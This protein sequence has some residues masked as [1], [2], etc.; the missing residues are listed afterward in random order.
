MLSDL[1]FV[2][3]DTDGVDSWPEG[4]PGYL[5]YSHLADGYRDLLTEACTAATLG[6][7]PEDDRSL[8]TDGEALRSTPPATHEE[9]P[10][11]EASSPQEG[12]GDGQAL[13]GTSARP[14][15]P[16]ASPDQ[17]VEAQVKRGRGWR[18]AAVGR[19]RKATREADAATVGTVQEASSSSGRIT[20][21]RSRAQ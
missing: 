11:L 6:W 9:P 14:E 5:A 16:S 8:N 4:L 2:D 15:V 7:A 21:A 19:A 1:Q 17:A 12:T 18:P 13:A 20:R 10:A 3:V